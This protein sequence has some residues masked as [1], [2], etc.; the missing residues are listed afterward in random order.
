MSLLLSEVLEDVILEDGGSSVDV[1]T[2]VASL[3]SGLKREDLSWAVRSVLLN[4]SGTG[5]RSPDLDGGR[6]MEHVFL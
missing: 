6:L 2:D 4:Q 5:V 1:W 3:C